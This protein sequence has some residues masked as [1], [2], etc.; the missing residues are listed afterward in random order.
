MAPSQRDHSWR[1]RMGQGLA[2]ALRGEDVLLVSRG[3][4]PV[5]AALRLIPGRE[6]GGGKGAVLLLAVPDDAVTALAADLAAEGAVRAATPCSTS[7]GC[8]TARRCTP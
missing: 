5:A 4:H 2:L 7:P 6:R 3:G 1:G 8:W